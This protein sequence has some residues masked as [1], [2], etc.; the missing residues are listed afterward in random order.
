ME[1]S[2]IPFRKINRVIE[3]NRGRKEETGERR[4]RKSYDYMLK[5]YDERI[6]E[7]RMMGEEEKLLQRRLERLKEAI[8]EEVEINKELL[9]EKKRMLR[10]LIS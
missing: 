9:L 2:S 10:E 6:I 3:R 5:K 4:H 1:E 8:S 7:K